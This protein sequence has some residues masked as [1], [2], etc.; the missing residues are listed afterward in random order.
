MSST[1]MKTRIVYP[2]FWLDEKFAGCDLSTKLLFC[3]LITNNQLTLT[4]YLHI[5]DRQIMFDTGLDV[6]QLVTGKKQLTDIKWCFF[7]EN[8]IYHNH[9]C[10]Y[11]DYEGRDRVIDAKLKEIKE[12]PSK[13]RDY[14]N[15]LITR[16]KPVL[17]HKPEIINQK[18]ETEGKGY[19]AFLETKKKL[20]KKP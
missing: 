19:Q 9:A 12:I 6:N 7:T 16:Y 4:P 18:P 15:P 20:F 10:A 2:Q 17:N 3:Y 8:W 13:V 5:T 14:F 1:K 11:I